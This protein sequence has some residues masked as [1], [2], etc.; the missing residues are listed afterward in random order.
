MLPTF[1]FIYLIY[2]VTLLLNYIEKFMLIYICI[3]KTKNTNLQH[4]K[5]A[6][7]L[8]NT[9]I[10]L[11]LLSFMFYYTN[12]LSKYDKNCPPYLNI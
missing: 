6:C 12:T 8:H 5:Y 10:L 4:C 9:H 7:L 11:L 1:I 3:K 2:V